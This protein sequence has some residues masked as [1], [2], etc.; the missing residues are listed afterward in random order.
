MII[1]DVCV[2]MC[3]IL[4]IKLIVFSKFIYIVIMQSFF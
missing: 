3:M 2:C 4:K 1:D